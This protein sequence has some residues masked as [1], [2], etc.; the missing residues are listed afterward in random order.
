[1]RRMIPKSSLRFAGWLAVLALLALPTL[2]WACPNCKVS[3]QA[4]DAAVTGSGQVGSMSAGYAY[5]IYLMLAVPAVLVA[6]LVFLI[7]REVHRSLHAT[8]G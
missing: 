4:T 3:V 1:M 8:R 6:G 2:G 5:S 7:R